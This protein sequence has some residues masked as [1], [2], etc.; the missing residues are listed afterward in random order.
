MNRGLKKYLK[1]KGATP[2]EGKVLEEYRREMDRVIPEISESIRRRELRA[3][4]LRVRSNRTSRSL[5]GQ[6]GAC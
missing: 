2:V 5:R 3:A 4:E 1:E 6:T